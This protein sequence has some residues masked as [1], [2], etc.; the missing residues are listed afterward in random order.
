MQLIKLTRHSDDRGWFSETFNEDRHAHLG[1]DLLFKQDNHVYS[2]FAGTVRGLHFQRPPHAQAKLVTCIRGR[3][4]DVAV[5]I[6]AG[7]PT[8]G[9]S[10][11][12][13][14]TSE[15]GLQAFIPVGFAHGYMTLEPNTE[16]IYKVSDV[17]TPSAEGGIRW[18]DAAL[19]LSWPGGVQPIV[20]A[21]DR[22]LPTFGEFATPFEH[23][24]RPFVLEPEA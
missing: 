10:K 5:D 24:G 7:S 19:R 15:N 18:D 1:V 13:E 2:R 16:V 17:Y 20:S 8:Y 9:A 3:I 23:D 22:L 11:C 4:W 6:R 12:A 14:L 21:K